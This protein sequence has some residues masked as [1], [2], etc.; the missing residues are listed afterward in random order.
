MHFVFQQVYIKN[1]KKLVSYLL[2]NSEA[3]SYKSWTKTQQFTISFIKTKQVNTHLEHYS[4]DG[5][6]RFHSFGSFSS[7]KETL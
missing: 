3:Q 5:G 7:I 6:A 1:N 2:K 4:C